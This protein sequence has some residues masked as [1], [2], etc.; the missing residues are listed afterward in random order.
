MSPRTFPPF[1][2]RAL[3]LALLVLV[4]S[5]AAVPA[6]D[7]DVREVNLDNGMRV[8]LY[9]RPGDPNVAAG[10]IAKVGSANERPGITGLAH[11]FEHMMFKGTHAIGTRKIEEDLKINAEQDRVRGE[12][13]R[14]QEAL[15]H[16]HRL[17]EIDDPSDPAA[18]SARHQE[19]LAEFE[20]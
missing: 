5:A 4:A 14:E 19:L 1:R 18:R 7:L 17:G 9:R 10:W 3:A 20:A 12:L 16:K 8:L 15:D 2:P 11:L 6:Q 13:R